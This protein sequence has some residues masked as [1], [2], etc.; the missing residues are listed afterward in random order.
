MKITLSPYGSFAKGFKGRLK[1]KSLNNESV[2]KKSCFDNL[3][4]HNTN[5]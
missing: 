2:I 1:K 3:N 4:V 5:I